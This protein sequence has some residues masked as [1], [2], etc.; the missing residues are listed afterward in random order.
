MVSI[1]KLA[2]DRVSRAPGLFALTRQST[3][4]HTRWSTRLSTRKRLRILDGHGCTAARGAG[5]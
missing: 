5:A 2:L 4:Q 1:R 3:R